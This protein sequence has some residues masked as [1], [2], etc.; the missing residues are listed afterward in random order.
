MRFCSLGSLLALLFGLPL[1]A[2]AQ[3]EAPAD[4]LLIKASKAY[5]WSSEETS[6]VQLEG[7]V[8][9]ELD[10]NK[11]SAKSA[12]IWITPLKG[13]VGDEQRAEIALIGEAN[14]TQPTGIVRGG[15]RLFVNARLRGDVRLDAPRLG[16]DRSASD[17][18]KEAMSMRPVPLKPGETGGPS[19]IEEEPLVP[20]PPTTQPTDRFRPTQPAT[21]SFGGFKTVLTPEG[22][23]AAILTGKVSVLQRLPNGDFVELQ[24]DRAVV[25]TPLK[26]LTSVQTGEEKSS[27]E[28]S[29]TGV[30]VEGDVRIARTPH[31]QQKQ[32][33]QF[34]RANRAYY[35]F[36]T[37]RAILTDV[38]LHST[39]PKSQVPMVVRA[40]L[41][42][43][44]STSPQVREF[45]AENATL[46]TSSF[47][48]PSYSIGAK[49]AY[50]RQSDFD[51]EVT[52]TR[53]TFVA[54]D[55]TFNLSGFPI[56]YLPVAAGTIVENG[57][58]RH[59]E[60]GH[61]RQFGY[62]LSSEWGLFET[63]A[64]I[65]PTGLDVSYHADYFTKRGPGIGLDAKYVGGFVSESTREPW[66]Y[67][68]DFKSY[69]VW[70]HGV[71][72]MG[73]QRLDVEPD[74]E[75][76][77]R[78]FWEHQHILPGDWQVQLSGGYSSDPTF[79]EQWLNR[80]FRTQRPQEMA[81][82]LKHQTNTEAYT[83]LT[84]LQP[85]S[86]TTVSDL[87]Q[88]QAEIER[89]GELSYRRI[90]DSFWEDRMTFFSAN[91]LSAV[92]FDPSGATLADLGFAPQPAGRQ[93]PGIPSFG[94]TGMPNDTTYRSDFRQEI[95]WP[96]TAGQFRV[97]PYAI[98]R[99][100]TY[101][102]S[103]AGG[104]TERLYTAAGLRMT[105]AFWRID[106]SVKSD[107]FDLH[108]LRH[109]IEP[110]VNLY[111]SAQT[112]DRGNLLIYD[113]PIDAI[114]DISAIQLAINQ[115]WQTKRG[116]PGNWRS[117]DFFTLNT[118]G[119]FF[120][121]QPPDKDLDPTDFR[122]LFFVSNPESSVPRNS[123][124]MDADWRISDFVDLL[125]DVQWNLDKSKLA[126]A[127]IGLSV[128]M[129]T[130]LSYYIGLRHIGLDF[131]EVVNGNTFVFED[132]DLAIFSTNY[133]LTTKYQLQ[134]AN[135]YD[136]AQN[137]NDR[138]TI[139]LVRHFD[140]FYA[141]VSFRVDAFQGDNSVFFNIWPEGLQPGS[142]TQAGRG[143]FAN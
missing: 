4:Q 70:D 27:I 86:F 20:A 124:N 9:I 139:S 6:I 31:N 142:S 15:Q 10:K 33:D 114:T 127:S 60:T 41:M 29:I 119:N 56:F 38:V 72:D 98:G 84:T 100:T 63:L 133:E 108:R 122:G 117:A 134:L 140:R 121:N 110:Q 73:K 35:D 92:R 54:H 101:S 104:S 80:D 68:G 39:D 116:G 19:V 58:L 141:A 78:F 102:Q 5:T 132:Q 112:R 128:H 16:G 46:T 107:L 40:S 106:D 43:Q 96:F 113:E 138:S 45:T 83:F 42:R 3:S 74:N 57:A 125:S 61:S 93:S 52:G 18:Y 14:L 67:S 136:L 55:T 91:T 53:T 111:T 26:S 59:V 69:A 88:E 118:E 8:T 22:T 17:L 89:L 66:S 85:N 76:R 62:S 123:I 32:G 94:R 34:L 77:G 115:R 137:R 21:T 120:F 65:P 64:M 48:T 44:L 12:V 7:P 99:Y 28:Q 79:N 47:N 1:A 131:V 103:A 75:F 25:F 13:T 129:G 135:S 97:V 11:L 23:V 143:A 37:D 105:T 24:A 90:G 2:H 81:L 36:T 82:Y 71:D 51:N 87:Y 95:D 30:Y 130:R 109:V 50:I 126:T 49:S